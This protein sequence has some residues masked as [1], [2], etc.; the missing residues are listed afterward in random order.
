MMKR[1]NIIDRIDRINKEL[2][3]YKSVQPRVGDSLLAYD[4][5]SGSQNDYSVS[6]PQ[7]DKRFAKVTYT[8]NKSVDGILCDL[9]I[10]MRQS[11]GNVMADPQPE[12]TPTAPETSIRV[13]PEPPSNSTQRVWQVVIFNNLN[14][15]TRTVYLKCFFTSTNDGSFT[16]SAF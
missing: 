3:D 11:N 13:Y 4:V 16:I 1:D 7:L 2:A 8:A 12:Y 14:I 9:K 5:A 6:V 10:F 15:A